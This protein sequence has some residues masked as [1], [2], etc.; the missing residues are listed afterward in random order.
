M[1]EVSPKDMLSWDNLIYLADFILKSGDH[2]VSLLGGEPLLHPHFSEFIHY[3]SKRGIH[4]SIF[5]SGITTDKKFDVIK[6]ELS[7]KDLKYQFICNVN[8][9]TKSPAN[10]LTKVNVFLETFGERTNLSFNIYE[11]DFSFDFLI[12]P[13]DNADIRADVFDRVVSMGKKMLS[14]KDNTMSLEQVFLR[15][16]EADDEEL[17]KLLGTAKDEEPKAEET[18]AEEEQAE[19]SGEEE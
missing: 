7:D 3:L 14:F 2:H 10:E 19:K 17:E 15:L 4:S 8:N 5:T 6:E 13:E 11:L 9:P 18:Q 12:E 1:G 16:T